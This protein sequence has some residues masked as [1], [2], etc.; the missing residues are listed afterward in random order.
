M[1]DLPVFLPLH[2]RHKRRLIEPRVEL[3]P[4][5]HGVESLQPVFL[6]CRHQYALRHLEAGIQVNEILIGRGGDG[7]FSRGRLG[8]V[9]GVGAGFEG[10][11][12]HGGEGAVEVVDCVEEIGGE[13]L[14]GKGF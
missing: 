11:R 7:I 6:E 9:G 8:G 5:V 2:L 13:A 14:D 12:G 10:F 3:T 1:K 4:L